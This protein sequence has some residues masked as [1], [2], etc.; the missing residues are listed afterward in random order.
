[1]NRR[2]AKCNDEKQSVF[3]S[4]SLSVLQS[5]SLTA[6]ASGQRIEKQ[7]DSKQDNGSSEGKSAIVVGADT[8]VIVKKGSQQ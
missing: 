3:Q 2:P 8:A 5:Y 7:E 1:M 4:F 6:T